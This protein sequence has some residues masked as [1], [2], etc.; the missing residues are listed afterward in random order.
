MTKNELIIC[1]Q[2]FRKMDG[3]NV[4]L[5]MNGE[6]K[7]FNEKQRNILTSNI[8]SKFI[9][10]QFDE[11]EYEECKEI[12]KNLLNKYE[13][14][15]NYVNN[16]DNFIELHQKMIN[17]MKNIEKKDI[18]DNIKLIDPIVTLRNLKYCCY[19]SRNNIHPRI[20]AE[21][22]YTARFPKNGRK[23]FVYIL[24]KL[25]NFQEDKILKCE[26]EKSI[27]N[28]F[29]FYNDTY[30]KAIYLAVTALKEGLHPL[31]IGEKGNGLTTLAK[32]VASISSNNNYEFLFCSSETSV[33]D[34]IGC[35]QPQIKIKNKIQDL[36][37]Y[38]KWCDGP[39]PRAGKKGVP[40]ILDNINYSKPQVIECIN[41]LLE[42]NTKYNIVEY[43]IL[44]KEN[45]GPIQMQ[46]GFS[47][48]G[49]MV[50]DKENKNNITKA[51]MNRSVAIYVDND[52]DINNNLKKI[53][54]I[55]GKNIG[56]QI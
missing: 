40:I 53:I 55:T 3:Y 11:M 52:I 47:I 45:E 1:N 4:I 31:L 24:D 8:L 43:N 51:L 49:T 29:L 5:T 54:E 50:L 21:I 25:G 20:A 16:I 48:I 38:I 39:I 17:E 12:F 22:S 34:L 15:K 37:A 42:D 26:I 9:V 19:F 23:D 32:L 36:S 13:N 27:I 46:K 41:P 35:Y 18:K 6:V 2:V 10:I 56:K 30:K 14:S 28:N 7:G 33:E 44:E